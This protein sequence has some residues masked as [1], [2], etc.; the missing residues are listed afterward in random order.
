MKTMIYSKYNSLRKPEFRLS[1][2]IIK[3]N[4]EKQV[5]KRAMVPQASSRLDQMEKAYD[6]LQGYYNN[7]ELLKGKRNGD[8]LIFPFLDGE[9]ILPKM[10]LERSS[11]N[12]IKENL[13]KTL[14]IIFDINEDFITAFLPTDGF[15]EVF[16]KASLEKIKAVMDKT[17]RNIKALRISNPDAIF[18]NFIRV[19]DVVYC[20]DYEWLFDFP[21]P[22]SY[23]KFRTLYFFFQD[24]KDSFEKRISC[25]DFLKLFGFGNIEL[26][27][28]FEMEDS[29]QD[30]I[31]G[32]DRKGIY[33]ERYRVSNDQY[34]KNY[35]KVGADLSASE[36]S[37]TVKKAPA[38]KNVS[39]DKVKNT[40]NNAGQQIRKNF[41]L[42]RSRIK[43]VFNKKNLESEETSR[44]FERRIKEL[45]DETEGNYDVWIRRCEEEFSREASFDYNPLISVVIYSGEGD[46]NLSKLNEITTQSINRSCYRNYE[47]TVIDSIKGDYV[48]FIRSGDTLSPYAMSEIVKMINEVGE[49][50]VIY[51]DEDVLSESGK[52]ELGFM[53][54]DWSTSYYYATAY[55]GDMA[56]F[57]KSAFKRAV[58]PSIKS[59]GNEWMYASILKISEDRSRIEH[60]PKVLKSS[61]PRE[62]KTEEQIANTLRIRKRLLEDCLREQGI[63]ASVEE[64]IDL[65]QDV[66]YL[67]IHYK[68]TPGDS[69]SVIIPSKDNPDML[70]KCIDKLKSTIS[71]NP[72]NSAFDVEIIVVDNGSSDNN[73]KKLTGELNKKNVK[74]IYKKMDFN[75]SYMCNLGVKSSKGKFIL[76]LNDDVE[77]TEGNWLATMIG[78]ASQKKTGA[79]GVML[80]Y[81]GTTLI[82]HDGVVNRIREP[83]HIFQ[84]CDATKD[85]YHMRTI[86]DVENLAVTAA[87][88][89]LER[90]KFEEVGGFNEKMAVAYNDVEICFKL[91]DKGYDNIVRNDIRFYHHESFSRGSDEKDFNYKRLEQDKDDLYRDHPDIMNSDPFYNPYLTQ[92]FSKINYAF[93]RF[94]KY[95]VIPLYEEGE[96]ESAYYSKSASGRVKVSLSKV[97]NEYKT[98]ND[99]LV[100]IDLLHVQHKITI[101]GWAMRPGDM[102]N[103]DK[104]A[105]VLLERMDGSKGASGTLGYI[106]STTKKRRSDVVEVFPGEIAIDFSGFYLK[107]DRSCLDPGDYKISVLYDNKRYK[108]EEELHI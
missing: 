37:G 5:I 87:C 21:I 41:L 64:N 77:V 35:K 27:M 107:I 86:A 20:L 82:Q 66:N 40:A 73:K 71:G 1:T 81:P 4:D 25:E 68:T 98:S 47:I 53:K 69:V 44:Y 50:S 46:G 3:E 96:S 45:T 33:L 93:E 54:P 83:I 48:L 90:S 101:E 36:G 62:K 6:M 31:F 12:T 18:D 32:K 22:L 49:S 15:K 60:V 95:D 78:Q 104:Y 97:L 11:L 34:R 92:N 61:M 30:Y 72:E 14:D 23:L 57:S 99:A 59:A 67:R 7:I 88:L 103:I 63:Q 26:N 13:K 84:K 74:Y 8:D 75:F 76:F 79:V 89:M 9:K 42:G 102:Y 106:I 10:D 58:L 19:G 91:Y 52:R 17:G 65:F 105:K 85:L 24:N 16:S 108:K 29:F 43:N 2:L 100:F 51:T 70:L 94:D 56:V 39:V 28:F 55:I 80:L 38:N